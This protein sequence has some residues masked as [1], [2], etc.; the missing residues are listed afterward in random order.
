MTRLTGVEVV[1]FCWVRLVYPAAVGVRVWIEP[2]PVVQPIARL[3]ATVG[4]TRPES[5]RA[6][7]SEAP[8]RTSTTG[9]LVATPLN[10]SIC[11]AT[12]A[13]TRKVTVTVVADLALAAYQSSPSE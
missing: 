11:R 12:V 7:L 6:L 9:L 4:V 10:S 8:A 3:V 2:W 5:A 13:A 1:L